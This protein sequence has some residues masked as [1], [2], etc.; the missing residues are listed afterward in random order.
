MID[1]VEI[2][3]RISR[4]RKILDEDP[5]SQIFAALAEAYRKKGDFDKAFRVCQNGLKIHPTYGAAHVVMA[6]INLDRGLYDWAEVEA[7][8]AAEIEGLTR[9]VELLL[10]EIHLYKGEF[11]QA[12][13]V[14]KKLN[15]ADPGNRQIERLLGIAERIPEEQAEL[16]RSGGIATVSPESSQPSAPAHVEPE[17][18]T[19][20]ELLVHAMRIHGLVGA[21]EMKMDGLSV[22][23]EWAATVDRGE[24][25][26]AMTTVLGSM[27]NG[28]LQNGFGHLQTCLVESG[29]YTFYLI[30]RQKS[31]L[32]F[33]ADKTANLGT[34]RMKIENLLARCR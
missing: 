31:V 17:R 11:N 4:C 6:K 24:V 29:K 1:S 2:D 32:V 27:T 23:G 26:T 14:L 12:I 19:L 13:K 28:L 16:H 25:V 15:A 9:N 3:E 21:I 22:D 34:V 30:G 5:N 20:P 8:K 33:V 10:A 7:N 18:L